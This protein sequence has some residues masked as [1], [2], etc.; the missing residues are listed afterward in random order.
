[1]MNVTQE[2]RPME[3]VACDNYIK[4]NIKRSLRAKYVRRIYFQ[5]V[6]V[7]KPSNFI[8]LPY[9]P[10][11]SLNPNPKLALFA[12]PSDLPQQTSVMVNLSIVRF[13]ISQS[14]RSA[15]YK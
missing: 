6:M 10:S 2:L 4:A 12:S 14:A 15:T 11:L 13:S 3:Y 7:V 8:K 9:M 5:N 1:M